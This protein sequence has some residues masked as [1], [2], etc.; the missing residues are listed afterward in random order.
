MNY[1]EE[2]HEL[3]LVEDLFEYLDLDGPD[4]EQM[5]KLYGVFK[6]DMIDEPIFINKIQVAYDKR[7]S[8]HPLFKGKPVGFEHICTRESKHSK[9]RYFD[10]E[11]TNKIHWIKPVIHFKEDARVRYFERVH[12]NG[13]N[14][15]YYW[16]HEK[17]YVVIIR[18]ITTN[19]Q[20]VTA[21]KVD[22]LEKPRFNNWYNDY[23][24]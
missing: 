21:F 5:Y 13:K 1:F 17:D 7:K 22:E 18:E 11:R 20:L 8:R 14:Q 3:D 2:E 23:K 16:L 19:L 6:K 12:A 9:K 15:Q 10:P 24:N 4:K